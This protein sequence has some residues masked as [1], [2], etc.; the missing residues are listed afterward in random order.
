MMGER[1]DVLPETSRSPVDLF[2]LRLR[3]FF[4]LLVMIIYEQKLSVV[5]CQNKSFFDSFNI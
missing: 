3:F 2:F 5:F 1:L 4:D